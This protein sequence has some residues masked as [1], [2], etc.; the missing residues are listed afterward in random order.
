[1]RNFQNTFERRMRSFINASSICMIVPLFYLVRQK[2]WQFWYTLILRSFFV[3]RFW[4]WG[5]KNEIKQCCYVGTL[6]HL[7]N[8]VLD[9]I[10]GKVKVIR[11]VTIKDIICIRSYES[12]YTFL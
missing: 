7:K 8:Q 11:I 3:I 2:S 6:E 10:R 9:S 1:M 4:C 12:Q 5:Q